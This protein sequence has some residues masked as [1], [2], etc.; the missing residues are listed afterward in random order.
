MHSHGGGGPRRD[1]G[2]ER[3]VEVADTVPTNV[4]TVQTLEKLIAKCQAKL[5]KCYASSDGCAVE[6]PPFLHLGSNSR[7]GDRKSVV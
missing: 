4:V 6:I 1:K 5:D 3:G 2:Y 7:N